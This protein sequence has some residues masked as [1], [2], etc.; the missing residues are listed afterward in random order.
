MS[1]MSLVSAAVLLVLVMD[2]LG[3]IPVFLTALKHV[4]AARQQKVILREM[5]IALSALVLFLFLGGQFMALVGLSQQSL[6]VAGGVVLMLVA[7]R[8]IFPTR[9]S[10]MEEEV[11]AEPFIV[12]M[13][14]PYVAGPS[15]MA[16]VIL[17]MSR[18]PARWPEWLG[19]VVL[20]W[21]ICLPVMLM[22]GPL[23]RVLGV[24]GLTAVER[25]MGLVL[26]TIAVEMLM[27]GVVQ[28]ARAHP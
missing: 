7:L 4:P 2:P 10:S 17:L 20:A 14:I 25:L 1:E 11:H 3:N 8:M 15:A 23:R 5:C 13:A 19:A 22:A 21:A 27:T 28:F 26:V 18:N 6:G 9:E 16:T 24:R 12:P